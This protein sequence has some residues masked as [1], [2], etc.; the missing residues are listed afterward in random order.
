MRTKR[1]APEAVPAPPRFPR[2]LWIGLAFLVVSSLILLG[3]E[4]YTARRLAPSLA[5]SRAW[6]AHTHEVIA[7]AQALERAVQDAERGQRGYV[8]AG[9]DAYLEPY[10]RA[11]GEVPV[12]L[13]RLEQLTTDNAEQKRRMPILGRQIGVK[14]DELRSTLD[15]FQR[16]GFEAGR[17]RVRTNRGLDAM[18]VISSLIDAT[19]AAEDALRVERQA[20]AEAEEQATARAALAGGAIALGTSLLGVVVLVFALRN[21]RRLET[22][23]R[24][25]EERFHR[26]VESVADYAFFMLDPEGR[27]L[28]W[29]AGAERMK[30]YLAGEI[31]G[32]HFSRFYTDEDR[33]AGLPGRALEAAAREGV[34][35][36]EGWRVRKDGTRFQAN[37]VISRVQGPEGRL[38]GFAKVTRDVTEQAAQR[39]ALDQ[40]REALVQAQKM[41]ALG[42][43]SGGV[44]HDFNNVLH[45]IGSAVERLRRR[46]DQGDDEANLLLDMVRRNAD[47]AAALT[48]RIL[49]F[50]RRQPLA[51]Q[52]LDPNKLVLGMAELLRQTLG[53]TV[54]IETVL[55]GGA[56][57]V[58]VDPN[59]LETAIL[60]LA[61]NAR[62]AMPRGGKLTIET[63]NTFLDE[64][65]AAAHAEV[66]AGQYVMIALS[67]T[68]TGMSKELVSRAFEPFF[69]T[70]EAGHGTGLGLSQVY[71]FIKQSGGHVK[72]YSE[73]GEGTTLKL[74]LQRLVAEDAALAPKEPRPA[75]PGKAG[76][77]ILVVE[78]DDDARAFAAGA[79]REHGYRVL[80]APDASSALR[81]LDAEPDVDL[82]FTDVGLPGGVTGR[83]LADE[84]KRR[85][86]T[87]KVLF[88]TAY[89]R[90][91]IV[92][93]GRLD[94]GVE[95]LLKPF[96]QT[97]LAAKVRRVL[98][99]EGGSPRKD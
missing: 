62:D 21:V 68:G 6:V 99:A 84:A 71:G 67:D 63:A 93:H 74:Y 85:R 64:A 58:S 50:G 72:I 37:V 40:A 88:T 8:I 12:L 60:N 48:Q 51:P 16:E 11:V 94:P 47:R 46:V 7:T 57:R 91:A 14:L 22:A 75:A 28:G 49:A 59:Q 36:A 77:T 29:N 55:A 54:T 95:L 44:A 23:R 90:N 73:P 86:P 83:Q 96:S 5:T 35:E 17:A 24:E 81:A 32:E 18:R 19:I 38:L 20:R 79:L 30:G 45:V 13:S 65:Y 52:P 41:E 26:F 43:L 97:D 3:L 82:L 66:T 76:E 2:A 87:L 4:V 69:T 78:D 61:V 9:D 70:K 92:H 39:Q 31:V 25:S 42:Q 56:W 89:A 53:E 1:P 34:Y 27:V 15:V 10:R 98:D 33:E 80:D